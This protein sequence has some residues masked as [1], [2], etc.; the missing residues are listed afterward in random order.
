[1][2]VAERPYASV[3]APMIHRRSGSKVG[4]D[5]ALRGCACVSV[6]ALPLRSAFSTRRAAR[7]FCAGLGENT[8]EVQTRPSRNLTFAV[9]ACD[10][11]VITVPDALNSVRVTPG[12]G[13]AR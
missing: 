3:T 5:A 7:L 10:W 12:W 9:A 6:K 4:L 1:M 8:S 11:F 2:N 13:V